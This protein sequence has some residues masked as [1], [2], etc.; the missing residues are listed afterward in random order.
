MLTEQTIEVQGP[1]DKIVVVYRG[2]E[3]ETYSC[4]PNARR[5]SRWATA[6]FFNDALTEWPPAIPSPWPPDRRRR[7]GQRASDMTAEREYE[8]EKRRRLSK[9]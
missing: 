2:V 4:T 7:R 1:G 6:A 9:R 3:R 8:P 5:G